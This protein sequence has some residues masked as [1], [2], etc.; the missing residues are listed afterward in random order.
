MSVSLRCNQ[1]VGSGWGRW[2]SEMAT[3]PTVLERAESLRTNLAHALLR[4]KDL[5]MV[6]PCGSR[7]SYWTDVFRGP[8]S[9]GGL[10]SSREGLRCPRRYPRG[11]G[12][13]AHPEAAAPALRQVHHRL[14]RL[15]LRRACSV[16][17][18]SRFFHACADSRSVLARG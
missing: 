17:G 16:P 14:G 9:L 8:A 12:A 4:H 7:C 1:K 11:A 18:M 6:L 10:P 13:G 5:E 15:D 3:Q 2:D